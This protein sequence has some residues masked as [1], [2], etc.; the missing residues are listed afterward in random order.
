MRV[1]LF[2]I[3]GAGLSAAAFAAPAQI[4][5]APVVK[6]WDKESECS[7]WL[8]GDDGKR[9][10]ASIGQSPDGVVVTLSDDVFKSWSESELPKVEVQFNKDPK[11]KYVTEGWVSTGGGTVGMFGFFLNDA[12]FKA[13]DRATLLELR[14]DGKLAVAIPLAA[15][16]TAAELKGCVMPPSEHSDSE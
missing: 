14:R 15:T 16:P 13:M 9:L 12:G 6:P 10:R 11:R 8:S 1:A 4:A 3:A 7:W 2:A 5:A